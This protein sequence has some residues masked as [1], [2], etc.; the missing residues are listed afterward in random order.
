MVARDASPEGPGT[1][2]SAGSGSA[3]G[4]SD[5]G[6]SAGGGSASPVAR[7][8]RSLKKHGV[9]GT[10]RVLVA[11]GAVVLLFFF[12]RPTPLS[13]ALGAVLVVLGEAWRAWAAG[14]L[15]KSKELAVSGP[16]RYVQNPLY[17]GR[18]C[19]LAG[20]S[21]M[22]TMPWTVGGATVPLNGLAL[23]VGLAI[24]FG[25][26]MPRKRRV[27]GDRLARLHGDAY[28]AWTR[29]VPEII[30]QLR[31]YGRNVRSWTAERFHD[32]S[33]GLMVAFV[34]AVTAA[35]AWRAG[36]FG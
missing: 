29:A 35:F 28:V 15:L 3:G 30:P 6:G 21:I 17:F 12:S 22:A 32:N 4:G 14:H 7:L 11:L 19:L 9:L 36:L 13:V 25:Y 20:F 18:L 31:P 1:G 26:Y 23:I 5:G 34:L 16:Y 27:E 2:V 24:F 10:L 33:E 8:G